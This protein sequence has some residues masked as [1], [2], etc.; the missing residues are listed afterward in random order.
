MKKVFVAIIA[1]VIMSGFTAYADNGKK[2]LNKQAL[3]KECGKN[4]K[5][6]KDC[7]KKSNCPNKPGC[8]CN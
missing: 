7:P 2:Q 8:I 5:P 6:T 3:K 4:C 1:T